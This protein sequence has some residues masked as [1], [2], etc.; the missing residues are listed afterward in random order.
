MAAELTTSGPGWASHTHA[1]HPGHRATDVGKTDDCA[2][3]TGMPDVLSRQWKLGGFCLSRLA[4]PQ[5]N[6]LGTIL[7]GKNPLLAF[8][9]PLLASVK[10]SLCQP[11]GTFLLRTIVA[12]K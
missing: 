5:Q 10:V 6:G 1:R 11:S 2:N 7:I 4:K 12:N 9:N 8:R 3:H